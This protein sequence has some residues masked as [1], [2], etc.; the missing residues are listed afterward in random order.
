MKNAVNFFYYL[1]YSATSKAPARIDRALLVMNIFFIMLFAILLLNICLYSKL[2]KP[3]IFLMLFIVALPLLSGKLLER[4]FYTKHEGI[5][6]KYK[7]YDK[8]DVYIK[9]AMFLLLIISMV[10]FVFSGV[11]WGKASVLAS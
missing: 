2:Y 6:S 11:R 5:I 1:V 4:Y 3:N 7:K 10:V 9:I 8:L